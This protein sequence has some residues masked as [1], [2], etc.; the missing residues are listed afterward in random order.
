MDEP[1][2]T[3]YRRVGE[4]RY[5]EQV[6]FHFE[7]FTVGDVFEHRP[8][9]TVTEMDNVLMSM[10]SMNAAP[11]HIDAAYCAHTQWGR[12]LV[13]S[14]VTL[15][16]VGGM[17]A[18]STSGRAIANLGWEHIRLPA[19]V[20]TG[21]TLYAESE[22]LSRRLSRSRPGEG[23]V[24]CRTTGSKSTGEVVLTFERSFLVPTRAKDIGDLTGY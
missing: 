14:L 21:D 1:A 12:P 23:I 9:R 17:A 10:L 8:G 7:D 16:I 5:R 22:I 24:G 18:R 3:G 13:S 19:P 6:G 20:F 11:L 2:I 15:S 4:Q